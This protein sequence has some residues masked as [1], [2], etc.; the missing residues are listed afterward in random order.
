MA[1][2]RDGEE[3]REAFVLS[4]FD[5]VYSGQEDERIINHIDTLGPHFDE[6]TAREVHV[7]LASWERLDVLTTP[8][9]AA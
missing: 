6:L 9:R 2:E 5:S 8:K 4:T 7:L 1:F 3:A